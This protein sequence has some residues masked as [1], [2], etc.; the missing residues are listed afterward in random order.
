M[1]SFVIICINTNITELCNRIKIRLPFNFSAVLVLF[2]LKGREMWEIFWRYARSIV[3][4][5]P[6]LSW[7]IRSVWVQWFLFCSVEFP[8]AQH[9]CIGEQ[10]PRSILQLWREELVGRKEGLHS[11]EVSKRRRGKVKIMA[12]YSPSNLPS[13]NKIYCQHTSTNM[14]TLKSTDNP[15]NLSNYS[16][17]TSK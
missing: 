10:G 7:G 16:I 8:T 12:R 3:Y 13:Y 5:S 15:K 9:V 14:V 2:R 17:E 1:I 6:R 11:K 4:G